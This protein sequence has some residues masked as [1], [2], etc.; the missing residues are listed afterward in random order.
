MDQDSSDIARTYPGTFRL[1]PQNVPRRTALECELRE[2]LAD[3]DAV[4]ADLRRRLD[5]EAEERRQL[6]AMLKEI[7]RLLENHMQATAR[8]EP[9]QDRDAEVERRT[10]WWRR[11]WRLTREDAGQSPA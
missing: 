9:S 1:M 11:W 3:K 7:Q 5:A 6:L 2:R 10:P 4:I 8:A